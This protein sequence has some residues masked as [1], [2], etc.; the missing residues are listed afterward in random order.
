MVTHHSVCR[1]VYG[2]SCGSLAYHRS[3]NLVLYHVVCSDSGSESLH[4]EMEMTLQV[5]M[6]TVFYPE[7]GQ[8]G[9][10]ENYSV[11]TVPYSLCSQQKD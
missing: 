3:N 6:S 9:V 1:S 11:R 7:S 10:R 8:S 4:Y 2:A 5:V